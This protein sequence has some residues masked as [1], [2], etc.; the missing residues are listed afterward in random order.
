MS[1]CQILDD[2][3]NPVELRTGD[4]VTSNGGMLGLGHA[5]LV[6]RRGKDVIVIEV[7]LAPDGSVH[8]QERDIC[9]FI[10]D[11]DNQGRETFL[12]RVKKPPGETDDAWRRKL[13]RVAAYMKERVCTRYPVWGFGLDVLFHL[14]DVWYCSDLVREAFRSEGIALEITVPLRDA[15][16]DADTRKFLFSLEGEAQRRFGRELGGKF[17]RGGGF[18][19]EFADPEARESGG[20]GR[21]YSGLDDLVAEAAWRREL[22]A[23]GA[24]IDRAFAA[25]A[26]RVAGDE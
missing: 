9:D 10:E 25:F 12:S 22:E 7:M 19:R 5:G 15:S 1:D 4:I 2:A 26:R 18:P 8:V 14:P 20:P 23:M 13:E 6:E 3:G 17:L 21:S 24:V 16:D 11:Y